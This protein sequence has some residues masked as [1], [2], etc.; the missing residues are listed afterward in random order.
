MSRQAHWDNVYT[1]KASD[2]VSW[3]QAE[4]TVSLRLLDRVSVGPAT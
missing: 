4:P 2:A 1:A 3:F